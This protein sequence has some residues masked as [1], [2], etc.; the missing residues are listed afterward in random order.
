MKCPKCGGRL[1]LSDVR[2]DFIC[3]CGARLTSNTALLLPI[4]LAIVFV[5][6]WFFQGL[7][8]TSSGSVIAALPLLLC[9]DM[10]VFGGFF[11]FGLLFLLLFIRVKAK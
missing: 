11:L 4:A 2:P 5:G 6:K 7:Y 8:C 10:V 9:N 3:Q 1:S